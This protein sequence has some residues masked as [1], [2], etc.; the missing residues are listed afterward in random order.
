MKQIIE[1]APRLKEYSVPYTGDYSLAGYYGTDGICTDQLALLWVRMMRRCYDPS[2]RG[3]AKYGARGISVHHTW[4]T[5]GTFIHDVQQLTGF[6]LVGSQLDKDYYSSNQYS[7]DTC[8]WLPAE[9]N[10]AYTTRVQPVKVSP[11]VGD[12]LIF[13][14]Q[15]AAAAYLCISNKRLSTWLLGT[16]DQSNSIYF[17]WR[18]EYAETQHPLRYILEDTCSSKQ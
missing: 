11:P 5:V 6:G 7:P 3:Y 17:G 2:A 16:R 8:V 4:H 13:L 1:V 18:F 15:T 12:P 9:V 10:A 14:S